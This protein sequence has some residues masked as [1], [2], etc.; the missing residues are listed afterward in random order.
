MTTINAV[1]SPSIRHAEFVRM[2]VG[3][4]GST[5]TYTFCNAAAP[6]TVSGI[7]FTNLGALLGVGD[8]Q[9]DIKAT[10]DDMSISLTGIDPVWVGVILGTYIKG[11]T[12]E[13]WRGFLDSNNQI[14]TTPTLQ[15]FKRYQGIINNV[16]I[17]ENFDT[18]A[19]TRI[20]TCSVSCSSMRRILENR[21]SGVKTN[22]QSWQFI[23]GASETSMNRVATIAN[24]YFDFGKPPQT[25][26]QSTD[27]TG[28]LIGYDDMG[29]GGA[30]G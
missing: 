28:V 3:Q 6:V 12:V 15:F 26:T 30:S 22:Q 25:Q 13:V 20:A 21:M 11:S 5:T 8:V 27:S 14:I 10:S 19:R 7:T 29:G 2:V 16:S 9:R 23:Y 1:T 4:A 24:T 17:T 18:Q